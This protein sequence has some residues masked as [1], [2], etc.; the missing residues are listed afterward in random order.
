MK[1]GWATD[2]HFDH[3]KMPVINAFIQEVNAADCD[4]VVITG[5][6]SIAPYLESHLGMLSFIKKHVY[7]VLGNHDFCGSSIQYV[8]NLT[9]KKAK[10]HKNLTW[11]T[12][13]KI[14]KLTGKACLIGHDSWADGRLGST[15]KY[16]VDMLE[17]RYTSDFMGLTRGAILDALS[18]LGDE[19]AMQLK[20]KAENALKQYDVIYAAMHVP[21]FKEAAW[22]R[23]AHSSEGFL[24]H[25]TCKAV[26]D[27]LV[28]V[29]ERN[30]T[31]KMVVLCGHTHSPG[32]AEILP[33]LIVETGAA[34]Y[35]AP[36]MGTI[37]EI[38]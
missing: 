12:E 31:K 25:F 24:P 15:A 7:F 20:I 34:E 33:N 21:P 13:S 30:P 19:A 11:L 4:A 35:R 10:S 26:G 29:M 14:I 16:W 9:K 1:L 22:H 5:D 2:I 38:E 23:G 18:M 27:A 37:F 32:H 36:V 3:A 17:Y 28:S 6:I 8:R